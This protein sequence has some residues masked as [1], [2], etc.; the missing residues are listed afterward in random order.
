MFN[1]PKKKRGFFIFYFFT[2]DKI[3]IIPPMIYHVSHKNSH[4]HIHKYTYIWK[5]SPEF[6]KF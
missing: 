2:I 5:W 6:M 4:L 3:T 1:N